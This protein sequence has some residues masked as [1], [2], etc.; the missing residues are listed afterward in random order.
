VCVCVCE[1]QRERG[2]VFQLL[3]VFGFTAY[4][5]KPLFL[6]R[7]GYIPVLF[8]GFETSI[9]FLNVVILRELYVFLPLQTRF[10]K[11]RLKKLVLDRKTERQ[12]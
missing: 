5:L 9:F 2:E 6:N 1:K 7:L 8:P 10:V 4:F 12:K 3:P 11:N